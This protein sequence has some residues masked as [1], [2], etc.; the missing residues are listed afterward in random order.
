MDNAVYFVDETWQ[1]AKRTVNFNN[2]TIIYEQKGGFATKEEAEN[3]LKKDNQKYQ[4]DLDRMKKIGNIS[5]TFCEYTEY[6]LE[7]VFLPNTK[8]STKSIG[9]WTIRN[10]ILPNIEKDILLNF[11]SPEYI[12]DVIKKCIPVCDS[13]GP[14]VVKYL[15]RILHDA[16]AQGYLKEDIRGRLMKPKSKTAPM[17]LLTH[18]QLSLL[19][20][21]VS[22]H[23]SF[24]F[25]F[26]LAL[27]AGLRSGEIM[28]LKYEDFDKEH[29]TLCV[30]RQYTTNY[31]L[32]ES[33]SHYELTYTME[34]KKPKADSSRVL[35]IPSF[36]FEELEK[37]KEYNKVIL[38]KRK[39]MGYKKLD[40]EY[41]AISP[42]GLRKKKGTLYSALNRAC[43]SAGVPTISFHALRHHFATMLIE[44]GV[45]LEEISKL[46][47]H[48]STLTTFNI[49]CGIMDADEAAT[50]SFNG[51]FPIRREG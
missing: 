3:A 36:L 47:G 7:Q 1:Y 46:L 13:A 24:Y 2:F 5:Y 8:T 25:E 18:Q 51:Y 34:E 14:C 29:Q 38:L 22:R 44:K 21:E 45:P 23:P 37:K 31:V 49:Y 33:N 4:N 40:D 9:T 41:V 20:E 32:A 19:V 6:W 39:K 42:F 11:V 17:K 26:L 28:G 50:E 16:Y 12:N 27:F 35:K 43:N 30:S 15:R 10:L 48:K